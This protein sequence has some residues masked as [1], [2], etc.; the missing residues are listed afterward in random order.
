[1]KL[2]SIISSDT[3]SAQR[4][5]SCGVD[6]WAAK[7]NLSSN[8][9]KVL[10]ISH[11]SENSDIRASGEVRA[12]GPNR[13]SAAN[14]KENGHKNSNHFTPSPKNFVEPTENNSEHFG[15]Y[16]CEAYDF[17]NFSIGLFWSS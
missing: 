13:A 12:E 14:F 9:K 16:F 8:L 4:I 5:S 6:I 10:M 3:P 2:F 17:G 7:L 15:G 1:M 11:V